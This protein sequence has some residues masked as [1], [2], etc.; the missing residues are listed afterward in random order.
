MWRVLLYI[1][2]LCCAGT[3]TADAYWHAYGMATCQ[4]TGSQVTDSSSNPV[5]VIVNVTGAYNEF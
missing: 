1:F 5:K 3:I 2:G 4:S